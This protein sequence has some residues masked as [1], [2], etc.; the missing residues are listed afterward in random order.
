MPLTHLSLFSGIGGIDLAAEWAGFETV[1]QVEWNPYAQ[2]V[3]EKHWPDVPRWKDVR[4]FT[5]EHIRERA[6]KEITLLSGGFPCQPHSVAG[7]HKASSDERDLWPEFRR[8]IGEIKPRWVLAENVRGLLT[9]EDGRFFRGIL[10][11][12]ADLGFNVG[13]CTYPAAWVGAVHRRERVFIV[14]NSNS[15]RFQGWE[16]GP[17]MA[18]AAEQ[19]SGFLQTDI[20]YDLSELRSYREDNGIKNRAHRLG[21]IGNMVMPQQIYPVTKAIADIESE[22]GYTH[23]TKS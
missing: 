22:G 15:K 14:A 13:W 20:K 18:G 4:E 11:D 23:G 3:L 17:Q 1:G 16:K 10:R 12:F 6:I 9:S 19:L 21:S 7:E 2:H 8:L 5:V